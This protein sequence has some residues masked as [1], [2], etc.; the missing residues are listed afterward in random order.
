MCRGLFVSLFFV[1]LIIFFVCG[2]GLHHIDV[3]KRLGKQVVDPKKSLPEGGT[4]NSAK[5][6][7]EA[8]IEVGKNS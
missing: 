5:H 7:C 3:A 1:I 6:H 8:C 4:L 2:N